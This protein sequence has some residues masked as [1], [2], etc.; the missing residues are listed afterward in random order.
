LNL[1]DGENYRLK[2]YTSA[3]KHY[4][5]DFVPFKPTPPIDSL[6]WQRDTTGV[7]IFVNTHDPSGQTRFYRWE[8]TETWQYH[9]YVNTQFDLVDGML[10]F[11]GPKDMIY[12]CW[13][14]SQ[15]TDIHIGSS[16]KLNE[17][18]IYQQKL[19]LVP[20]GSE[21]LSV[22]YSILVKQYALTP[23]AYDYWQTLKKNT[24][25]LGGI[26][27]PQ[28]STLTGNIHCVE[29]P[30][31]PVLGFVSASSVQQLRLFVNGDIIDAWN[32]VPYYL[33]CLI[34]KDVTLGISPSDTQTVQ[35]Y[36]L[37]PNHLYT[38]WYMDR[39]LYIIIQN[40]CADCRDHGG[41]NI[42]PDFWP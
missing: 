30:N 34:N 17:D 2:I 42:K 36:L 16:G 31:E 11:R 15:S 20:T 33:P 3:G 19:A 41:S 28:P 8:Y 37:S 25:A 22:Y 32:Y 24:E 18:L 7:S 4:I 39:G 26:F 23:E 10:T 6:N 13:R 5:S 35:E 40:F 14:N 21:K 29:D 9:T 1:L 27:D 38:L 12:N